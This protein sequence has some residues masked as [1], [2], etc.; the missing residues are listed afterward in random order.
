MFDVAGHLDELRCWPTPRLVARRDELVREQRRLHVEELTVLRVLDERGRVDATLAGRDGVSLRTVRESVETARALESLPAV[1]AAAH[2]GE[3]SGEQLGP[4]VQ[5]ADESTD[6]EWA[7]RAAHTAPADLARQA[8]CQSK[9]TVEQS[10]ARY[11]ARG[12]RMWWTAD[13]AML[14]LH[15][16]LPDV[17]GATFEATIG[18]L[19]EQAKPAKGQPWDSWEHRAAD[20]LVGLC[21]PHTDPKPACETPT[22]AAKPLFVVAVP[23]EGPAEVA[24]VPLAD[25]LVEQLRANAII[26]P[27]LVDDDGVPL[28]VGKRFSGLS[29]K[30]AR[31]VLLRDGHCRIPGCEIR[32]GLHIHHLR[33]RSWGGTDNVS[34]LAAVCT[35]AGHHQMLVP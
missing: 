11:A 35:V 3:L 30:I 4:V 6:A 19:C 17:M 34:D 29:P 21:D 24:G 25:E 23:R 18:R 15:G 2:A 5:L 14:H 33:P 12:V 26:E 20:A 13:K 10:R 32:H 9:P 16:Q 31:A 22:L 7:M 1:A 28:V 27:A 8:R